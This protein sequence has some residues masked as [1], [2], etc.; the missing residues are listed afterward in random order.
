MQQHLLIVAVRQNDVLIDKPMK[1]LK[2]LELIAE[3]IA[4]PNSSIDVDSIISN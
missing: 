4:T 2:E 1:G 3:S